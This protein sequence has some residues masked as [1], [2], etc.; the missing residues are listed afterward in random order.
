M[1]KKKFKDR[2][3]S[4]KIEASRDRIFRINDIVRLSKIF[5]PH[6]SAYQKR[7]AFVA[8]FIEIRN[9]PDQRIR[10][11]DNIP[12]QYKINQACFIKTR[13]KLTR[14]GLISIYD[15]QWGFSQKFKNSMIRLFDEIEKHQIPAETVHDRNMEK[16]F[17]EVAKTEPVYE[18]LRKK[19]EPDSDESLEIPEDTCIF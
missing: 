18:Q 14:I 19:Q 15:G 8:I 3:F 12:D 16:T 5:F 9:A 6:K 1:A 13:A 11:L 10:S 2:T 17:V 7:S 4:A